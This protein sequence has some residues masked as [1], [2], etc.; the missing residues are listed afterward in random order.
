MA[1]YA[2]GKKSQ[3]ISDRSG[4]K[5][6]YTDLKTTWD[7]LRVSP[8]DWEPK[9]PQLTPA[10]NV[11]DA[12]ALFNPRPDTDP[13]NAEVF[14]GYNFDPFID[15]RQRPGVGVHGQGAIGFVSEVHFDYIFDVTGVSGSG[16]IGT[17]IVSDNEDVVVSGVAGTGATGTETLDT[18][19][20]PTGVVG[21]GAFNE[22]GGITF[23]AQ[24]GAQLST[25]QQKFGTASLLLDGV[26]DSVV[27]DQTYNFGSNVFT[28]DMWVR[29]TSGTQDDIFY[30]SRDSTSNNAI[31]LRQ[32][33]DNLLVLRA[34][35]TLFNVN[36]VFSAD[37]WVHI[38]ITRGD[39]FGN[40]FA[41]YVN[42]TKEGSTTFGLTATAADIHI[43]SDFNGSNNWAGYID[44]LRIS[45]IDRYSG[46]S[47]VPPSTAYNP[48][49][50]TV[51]L[52][53]FDGVNG[54]T[55]IA[56]STGTSVF[57]IDTFLSGVEGTGDIGVSTFFITTDAPVTSVIGTGAIGSEL[58]ETDVPDLS[59]SGTGAIGTETFETFLTPDASVGTGAIGIEVPEIELFETGVAG[60]GEVEGFGISGN[61]NIQLLVTG[62]SGIGATGAIGEEVS[63]SEAI[64]TGVN[65]TGAIGTVGILTE[66]GWGI[67]EWGQGAW[68]ADT[69][70]FPASAIGTGAVGSV[71]IFV[72][73]SWGQGGWGEGVWQGE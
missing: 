10:K 5:V 9:Q 38:A 52:L 37:T 47:F 4:L 55:S 39:P 40:T 27:S 3:A 54:S 51:A 62:I 6:P 26:D 44:E 45:D 7:G 13:E 53:H 30:D 31:A 18:G 41:V 67:G 48:D 32:A 21:T 57:E 73:T 33:G 64:E 49:G 28:V 43:G 1:K 22:E 42:G 58:I 70:P 63:A 25:T 12:T 60:T 72:T 24:N 56:N 16:A 61:G 11:V 59:V 36:D 8:E 35:G 50:N 17:V 65:G 71:S 14:I 19:A 66:L 29:P 23:T 15:P 20:E 2:S 34:N 68:Q 69:Q 46:T